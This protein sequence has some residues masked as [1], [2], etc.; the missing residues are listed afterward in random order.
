MRRMNNKPKRRHHHVWQHYLAPWVTSGRIYCL[1]EG[2]VFSSGTTRVAVEKDF[3]KFHRLTTADEKMIHLLFEKSHPSAR[4]CFLSFQET[5][6]RPFRMIGAIPELANDPNY[7]NILEQ[8]TSDVLEELHSQVEARFIP[9]LESA[10][11]EDL[12]FYEDNRCIAFIDFLTKQYMRTKGVKERSFI[13]IEPV[14][15]ADM[16]RAWSMLSIMF[17]QNIGASLYRERAE[18]KLMLLKNENKISFITGDQPLINLRAAGVETTHLSIYYPISP[19]RALWLGEVG[20]CCPFSEN[21][22]ST[23]EVNFLNQKIA[24]ASYQQIFSNER[25]TLESFRNIRSDKP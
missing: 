14:G 8:Y 22:L 9:I 17:A 25:T 11:N 15:N 7:L 21:R 5:L 3:Y 4:Q 23:V 16:R 1:Q 6:M 19:T 24:D 13:N 12:S 20:E 2:K 18:R 10:M